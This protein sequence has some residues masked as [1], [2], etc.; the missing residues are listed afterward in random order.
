MNHAI[1]SV[2][3]LRNKAKEVALSYMENEYPAYVSSVICKAE[4]AASK[5][6]PSIAVQIPKIILVN[7]ELLSRL[8]DDFRCAGYG[9]AINHE[10]SLLFLNWHWQ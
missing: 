10:D 6:F 5:G 1:P 4:D 8:R 3:T 7:K 9:P 2:E